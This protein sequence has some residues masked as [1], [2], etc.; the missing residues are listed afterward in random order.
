MFKWFESCWCL[1]FI[2][3]IAGWYPHCESSSIVLV[4]LFAFRATNWPTWDS[5]RLLDPPIN[6][7]SEH[8]SLPPGGAFNVTCSAS[9]RSGPAWVRT[10]HPFGWQRWA[11]CRVDGSEE[12]TFVSLCY[13]FES[14]FLW[15]IS[16]QISAA[17]IAIMARQTEIEHV[18]KSKRERFL[19]KTTINK[20]KVYMCRFIWTQDLEKQR[21]QCT[22]VG[23]WLT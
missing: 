20:H 9:L 15:N 5:G 12:R 2:S 22:F 11:T 23:V 4:S 10:Y 13:I 6:P 7:I 14:S 3:V 21:V 16:E 17:T 19:I 1:I 8:V 18:K